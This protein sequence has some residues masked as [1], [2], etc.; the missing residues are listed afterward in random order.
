MTYMMTHDDHI[1]DD[2]LLLFNIYV[3]FI[4]HD[5]IFNIYF[6]LFMITYL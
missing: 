3:D 5:H 2:I 4:I 6:L 1:H